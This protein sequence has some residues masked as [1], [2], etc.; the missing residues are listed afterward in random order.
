LDECGEFYK[1]S[2]RGGE[3]ARRTSGMT[4]RVVYC[5]LGAKEVRQLQGVYELA[6]AVKAKYPESHIASK[7]ARELIDAFEAVFQPDRTALDGW[8]LSLAVPQGNA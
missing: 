6:R 4:C 7:A 1:L 8:W 5:V 3:A 2:L